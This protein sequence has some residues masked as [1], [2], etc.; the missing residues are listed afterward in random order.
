[1]ILVKNNQ[2]NHK[3]TPLC[4]PKTAPTRTHRTLCECEL[5][6]PSK[7]E[8][9]PEMKSVMQQFYD[10]TTQRFQE[11]DEK[12]QEKRQIYKDKCDKE[13][14]K[15]ILK[16]K[17]EKELNEKFSSLHTDIESDAIPTCVCEKSMADKVEKGCLRCGSVLGGGVMPGFGAIG[18]TALYALNQLKPTAIATA[19]EE[20]LKAGATKILAA[21]KIAG[22]A[23]GMKV[24]SFELQHF[25][26][27]ELFPEIFNPFVTTRHY[28]EITSIAN[29]LLAKY[30]PTCTSLDKSITVPAAC[31][32]FQIKLG[33]HLPDGSPYG[34]PAYN[35][36]PKGLEG[37]LG[38][39]T[40]GAK[41]AEALKSAKLTTEI[42]KKQTALIEAGFDSSTTSIYASIIV[43][44]I[45]VLIMVIIYLILRYR[46]KKKMKKKLLYI[47]LLEE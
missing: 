23:A 30:G 19:V 34:T 13:I 12:L 3:K 8:N 16:D 27:D 11:Y 20:A 22:D 31:S 28:N 7:Y 17:I 6:A 40:Q 46:R 43:I 36:I 47:K 33:I 37:I 1:M 45:I 18:G 38:K 39:A 29:S 15:I 14:Q 4:T 26:V 41:A 9:D 44:L 32:K 21:S 42:T 24:V 35:A 2:R 25:G 5:Y 10:R